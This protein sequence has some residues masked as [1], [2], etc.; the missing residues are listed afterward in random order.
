MQNNLAA[1]L[2]NRGNAK[3]DG[4]DLV[5]A[6]ADFDA[7]IALMQAIRAAL[8]EAWPVPLRNDLAGSLQN[9]GAAKTRTS[10][11]PS[12]T[13]MPRSACWMTSA[14]GLGKRPGA[15]TRHGPIH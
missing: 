4:G 13:T 10:R 8:G 2:Q 1:V 5:D 6:V 11:E 12:P 15:T 3:A 7:G 9:R 14:N